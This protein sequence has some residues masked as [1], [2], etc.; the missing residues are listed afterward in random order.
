MT[1]VL[2]P[3]RPDRGMLAPMDAPS[4]AETLP[5]TYRH[6]LDRI[7]D[8]E[9][10]GY[11]HEADLVRRDAIAVYSGRWNLRTGVRLGYLAERAERVLDG[12]LRPRLFASS[13]YGRFSTWVAGATARLHRRL[14]ARSARRRARVPGDLTVERPVT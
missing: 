4:V 13:R 6:V 7:A 1:R 14:R 11:R 12:R 10:A 5:D 8:L 9:A 2:Y 3:D